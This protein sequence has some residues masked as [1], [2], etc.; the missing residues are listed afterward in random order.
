MDSPW[1]AQHDESV[2]QQQ[3]CGQMKQVERSDQLRIRLQEFPE[4]ALG[5]VEAGEDI[6]SVTSG[7]LRLSAQPQEEGEREASH[8][9]GF[10]ELH[11]MTMNAV[12]ARQRE[13]EAAQAIGAG[14]SPQPE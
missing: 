6:E 13:V 5:G 12:A 7:T 9:R 2:D 8:G 4:E 1:P 11:R 10:V 3:G 14:R